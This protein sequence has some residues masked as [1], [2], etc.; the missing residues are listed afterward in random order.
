MST[1][2][3]YLTTYA[4]K[5]RKTMTPQEI[6]LWTQFLRRLPI[7]VRRQHPI[8]PYIVDFYIAEQKTVIELDGSQHYED[9][10]RGSDAERD[11]F[12]REKGI[13]VLRYSNY[14]INRQFSSVCEDIMKHLGL[15]QCVTSP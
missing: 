10:V 11:A 5:L 4:Q 1:E 13:A 3:T 14:E 2:R 9:A 7:R 8:G 15:E 12:L 6:R